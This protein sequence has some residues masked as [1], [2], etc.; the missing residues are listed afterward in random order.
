MNYSFLFY[1]GCLAFVL[2]ASR[3][4]GAVFDEFINRACIAIGQEVT[5]ELELGHVVVEYMDSGQGPTMDCFAQNLP[6]TL[7]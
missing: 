3:V 2:R 1:Y 5:T 4:H 7:A 6:V